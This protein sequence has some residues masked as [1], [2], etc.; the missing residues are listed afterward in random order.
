MN[1]FD[2]RLDNLI[3]SL[4]KRSFELQQELS[5]GEGKGKKGEK[6]KGEE[7]LAD[8]EEAAKPSNDQ[9]EDK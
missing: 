1:I 6:L 9:G 5:D 2:K 8:L 3:I 4:K 7:E